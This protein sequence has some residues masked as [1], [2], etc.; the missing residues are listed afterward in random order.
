MQN[1]FMHLLRL[2]ELTFFEL[3]FE[4]LQRVKVEVEV[5]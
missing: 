5:S 3:K 4:K 1:V 2:F